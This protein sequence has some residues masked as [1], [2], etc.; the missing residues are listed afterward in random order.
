MLYTCS[1]LRK[2]TRTYVIIAW[3]LSALGF[4]C[5]ASSGLAQESFFNPFY[6]MEDGDLGFQK[7]KEGDFSPPVK[8]KKLEKAARSL[9]LPAALQDVLSGMLDYRRINNKA[10]LL[11]V[12]R[13]GGSVGQGLVSP[14]LPEG[15][16]DAVEAGKSEKFSSPY[17]TLEEALTRARRHSPAIKTAR[18][19]HEASGYIALATIGNYGPKIDYK[20]GRGREASYNGLA[21][22]ASVYP[23][24]ERVDK[25]L[26]LRQP[27]LD[28]NLLAG[29]KR[30]LF[31]E[32]AAAFNR[33]IS[34][35]SVTQDVLA[36]YF[37]LVQALISI[38]IADD[39]QSRLQGLMRYIS[40]R[41]QTGVVSDIE[42]QRVQAA[43]LGAERV[44][45]DAVS[46][47]D[48]AL[49]S[50]ERMIGDIPFHVA[51]PVR[52]LQN[53]PKTPE[54]ALPLLVSRSAELKANQ[55]Q[56][57]AAFYD[58]VAAF[59]RFTPTLSLEL[60]QYDTKNPSGVFGKTQDRRAL[61][62]MSMNLLSG[63]SDYAYARAQIAKREQVEFQYQNVYEN[64]I[65]RLRVYYLTLQGVDRQIETSKKEYLTY[66][67]VVDDYDRQMDVAQKSI[68]DIL[69]VNNKYF[70]AKTTLINLSIKKIQLAY[71]LNYYLKEF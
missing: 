68:T 62:T 44:K 53:M 30:D 64:T 39:Y 33:E 25:A 11:D 29:Y 26:I 10:Y 60:G 19:A 7:P 1:Q 43:S 63:G 8:L 5:S 55:K 12:S 67:A 46:A 57:E 14:S 18:A 52:S 20:N 40:S 42:L 6:K 36:S 69:D 2:N 21:S 66:K 59:A 16:L 54:E 65:K 23:D 38:S 58:Q 51:F 28:L 47:R 35:D 45:F 27:V 4:Q 50:V 56:V 24:H 13:G 48:V 3:V 9:P 61:L 41:A 15:G 34:E 49:A 71:A 32:E 70:Q 37:D 22:P 31:T 17:L